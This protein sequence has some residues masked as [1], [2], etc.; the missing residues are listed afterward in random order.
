MTGQLL[1]LSP[2]RPTGGPPG[3]P[4]GPRAAMAA[5][6]RD[7]GRPIAVRAEAAPLTEFRDTIR[8]VGVAKPARSIAIAPETAGR[9]IAIAAVPGAEVEKGALLFR[10]DDAAQQAELR[11]AEA[12]V[13]E[14]AAALARVKRLSASGASSE[15][16]LETAEAE[17][18]RA[19]AARDA[20]AHAL[21]QREIR[22]PFA[23]AVSLFD[24]DI[25]DR[26]EAGQ[27][28]AMLDDLSSVQIAF[29][30]P[31]RE[32]AHLR[33][34]LPVA[35]A[36]DAW[37]GRGFS[38]A[39]S[40]IDTRVSAESR[41]V[42]LRAVAPNDDRA[43]RGG[44]FLSV[45][46]TL[47]ARENPAAPEGALVLD[48]EDAHV[49]VL[50]DGKAR[51]IAVRPGAVEDGM[52]EIAEGLAPGERVISSD[53]HRLRDGMAVTEAAPAAAAALPTATVIR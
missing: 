4:G 23:G 24:L 52:V 40:A 14:T 13:K 33:K 2:S 39:L 45:T 3:G 30:A 53:L 9:V 12:T 6:S 34:G 31:E 19:A 27:E 49:F 47:S 8:A 25:G 37:P 46:L 35:L 43:L 5:P 51:R 17:A 42:A 48:G 10:L 36:S 41:S 29:A 7:A 22:A 38:A 21:A 32:L 28:I 11:S 18:L 1:D 26:V 20:A 44:M 15:A 16:A 50:R